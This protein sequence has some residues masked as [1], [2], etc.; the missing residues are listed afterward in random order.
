MGQEPGSDGVAVEEIKEGRKARRKGG[1]K[2]GQ[3]DGIDRREDGGSA[4][5]E[6]NRPGSQSSYFCSNSV[7]G[8]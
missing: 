1:K 8:P 6:E 7:P 2:D 5:R 3:K 4:G